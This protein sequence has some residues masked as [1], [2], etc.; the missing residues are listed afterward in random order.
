MQA[1]LALQ[2]TN[3]PAILIPSVSSCLKKSILPTQ[4]HEMKQFYK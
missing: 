3:P 2:K 1:K 4:C